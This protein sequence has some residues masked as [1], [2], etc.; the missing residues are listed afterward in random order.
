M[1]EKETIPY[2]LEQLEFDVRKQI[3]AKV[4]MYA[5]VTLVFGCPICIGNNNICLS[6]AIMRT[7]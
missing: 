7:T 6:L 5:Y 1:A 4:D 2:I 3:K